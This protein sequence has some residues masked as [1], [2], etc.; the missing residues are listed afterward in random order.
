MAIYDKNGT[1]THSYINGPGGPIGV[2]LNNSDA[3]L[4][5]FLKDHLGSTRVMVDNLGRVKE[6]INYDPFGEILE[7]WASYSEP[8]TFTGKRLD[9]HSTFDFYYFG[10]RYY[11][12]RI[13]Q[14]AS[15]DKAGQFAGLSGVGQEESSGSNHAKS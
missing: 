11:D 2:Y 5:Y 14:F 7:S 8:M 12:Y 1:I 15:V 10:S 13:G 6:Y 3:T 4:Y 9:L